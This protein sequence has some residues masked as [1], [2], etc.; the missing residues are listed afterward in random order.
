MKISKQI[1]KPQFRRYIMVF[2]I[3]AAT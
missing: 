3:S 1:P 2:D